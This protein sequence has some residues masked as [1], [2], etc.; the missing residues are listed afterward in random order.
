MLGPSLYGDFLFTLSVLSP[1]WAACSLRAGP[2]THL[3]PNQYIGGSLGVS[4]PRML[5]RGTLLNFLRRGYASIRHQLWT[6]R[7]PQALSVHQSQ[8]KSMRC[9]KVGGALAAEMTGRTS[10]KGAFP[11]WCR[12]APLPITGLPYGQLTIWVSA[13]MCVQVHCVSM[14]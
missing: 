6:V 14:P 2:G 1:H 4:Q 8:I 11:E 7:G 12:P 9:P 3:V 13:Y 5:S 10:H